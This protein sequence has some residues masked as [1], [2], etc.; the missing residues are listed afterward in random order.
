MW[1]DF[2]RVAFGSAS[3]FAPSGFLWFWLKALLLWGSG[4]RLRSFRV[5]LGLA[6]G[7]APLGFLGVWLRPCFLRAT[8]GL[9]CGS[10]S[11]GLLLVLLGASLL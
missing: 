2:F 9:A 7:F 11:F 8:L 3:A 6:S 1:L 5:S 10:T 4:L